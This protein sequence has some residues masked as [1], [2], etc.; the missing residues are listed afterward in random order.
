MK[1]K[2]HIIGLIVSAMFV[3][4]IIN[5]CAVSQKIADKTG[6]QLWGENCMR[7]HN[8]PSPADYSHAQWETIGMHMRVRANLTETETNK[9]VEFLQS[10]D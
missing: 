3:A 4:V 1:T 2:K 6:G 5:G 9:I 8:A 7:C 10:G